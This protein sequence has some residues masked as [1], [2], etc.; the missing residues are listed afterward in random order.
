MPERIKHILRKIWWVTPLLFLLMHFKNI[1]YPLFW[2][3][4]G[5]TAM[6]TL[7]VLEYGYPKV[8]D[9]KNV[10]YPIRYKDKAI[11]RHPDSDAY[12]GIGWGMFYFAAPSIWL[13][14]YVENIYVKTAISRI[15]FS[16]IGLTALGILFFTF[17]SE[18]R[19]IYLFF[20]FALLTAEISFSL[21]IKEVRYISPALFLASLQFLLWKKWDE[22]R[23]N[24]MLYV[25][26]SGVNFW[27]MYNMF[28]PNYFSFLVAFGC[29]L[30]VWHQF[31][32]PKLFIGGI[33]PG[34]LSV[35][36]L[37]PVLLYFNTFEFSKAMRESYH[38]DLNRILEQLETVFT[39]FFQYGWGYLL[40]F[41]TVYALI[42]KKK[43]TLALS[44]FAWIYI[45]SL[46]IIPNTVY[47]R[48]FIL[49]IALAA[50][51]NVHVIMDILNQFKPSMII[52]VLAVILVNLGFPAIPFW[53]GLHDR[54]YEITHQ[55]K[56]PLDYTIPWIMSTYDEPKNLVIA[57]NYEE[58][59]YMYYLNSKVI[60]GY[61]LNNESE[62][63][64][65]IPDIIHFRKAWAWNYGNAEFNVFRQKTSYDSHKF[66]IYEYATNT[67]PELNTDPFPHPFKTTTSI[68]F[69]VELETKR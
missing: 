49:I 14:Q 3:D 8:D 28:G 64:K 37:I 41:S 6:H 26:L 18:N 53:S 1:Q 50:F 48:Y 15:W 59:S 63:R 40:L 35:V 2:N 11:A 7:R 21:H 55:Y 36:L 51:I 52:G 61:V 13:A 66:N 58:C 9:G 39:Y 22:N 33:L 69:N 24:T 62:D 45:F 31:S 5:E 19:R 23:V 60:M 56:G 27:C 44:I 47:T 46:C 17:V 65:Q 38:Q 29:F 43:F 4:E 34:M 68:D 30:I 10:I 32:I 67:I 12:L 57:T 25:F 54:I 20:I 42:R 16:L